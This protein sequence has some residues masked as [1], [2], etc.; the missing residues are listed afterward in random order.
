[1]QRALE[2]P[3]YKHG[4]KSE[5]NELIHTSMAASVV[6]NVLAGKQERSTGLDMVREHLRQ[7]SNPRFFNAHT[8]HVFANLLYRLA[9]DGAHEGSD[10]AVSI[11]SVAEA[12]STIERTLQIIGA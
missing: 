10:A 8:A 4:G 6:A 3:D 2:T 1:Y 9:Q 5:P 11:E 7:A 12:L